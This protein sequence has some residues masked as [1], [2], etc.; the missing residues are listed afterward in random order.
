MIGGKKIGEG[1]Y[2][3]VYRPPLRC[4]G[5]TGRRPDNMV[6]KLMLK[7][8]ALEEMIENER[9][10]QIDKEFIYHLPP[11]QECVPE[12]PTLKDD[13]LFRDCGIIQDHRIDINQKGWDDKL[14]VLQMVDG[15]H[16]LYDFLQRNRRLEAKEVPRFLKDFEN[17]I[18]GL[19]HMKKHDY[20]HFDIKPDN[21]V[22]KNMDG[23]YRFNY[24]D[25]GLS[26]HYNR[27]RSLAKFDFQRGYFI[28]PMEVVLLDPSPWDME[29][30]DRK[31][32]KRRHRYVPRKTIRPEIFHEKNTVL[33]GFLMPNIFVLMFEDDSI[34]R[35]VGKSKKEILMERIQEIYKI[36]YMS[37]FN[38]DLIEKGNI[39]LDGFEIQ[40]YIDLF[41]RIEHEM[42]IANLQDLIQEMMV[43]SE[44]FSMGLVFVEMWSSL[45]GTLFDPTKE[46]TDLAPYM[47]EFYHIILDSTKP[48]FMDRLSMRDLY[49]RYKKMLSLIQE[50]KG[51]TRGTRRLKPRNNQ[52]RRNRD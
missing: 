23:K 19:N 2:G 29:E 15:G 41:N 30:R 26:I 11:P 47:M 10:N 34:K 17:I 35:M 25:F 18:Y 51:G 12:Y 9:I 33:K 32:L 27:I 3:C 48:F 1:S 38:E 21:L 13:N 50:R 4:K 24:I 42:N 14:L 16:S 52:T 37:E 45:T 7:E 36:S 20:L 6:S 43:K 49:D 40:K 39:Y 46:P 31:E 28:R 44:V 22:V 8:H 5:Q